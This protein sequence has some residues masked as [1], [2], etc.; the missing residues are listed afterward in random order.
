MS[1]FFFYGKDTSIKQEFKVGKEGLNDI[2]DFVAK[3]KRQNVPIEEAEER[4]RNFYDKKGYD[5]GI[6]L[7]NCL[8]E[9]YELWG[10]I[11]MSWPNANTFG[12]KYDVI[13]PSKKVPVSVP[14][15]GWR[16]D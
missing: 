14:D 16:L 8:D 4:L 5:R 1:I 6:T 12:D 10:K 7:Y 2:Y 11:N 3:L 13:H 9:N 15:R